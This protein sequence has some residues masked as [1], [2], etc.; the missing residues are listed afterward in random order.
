LVTLLVSELVGDFD[1]AVEPSHLGLL[2]E[3]TLVS[4]EAEG[5]ASASML[6]TSTPALN[7]PGV[8]TA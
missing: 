5:L 3:Q 6:P 7:Q 1:L 2:A 4:M 8:S